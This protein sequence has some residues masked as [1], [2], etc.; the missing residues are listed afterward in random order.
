MLIEDAVRHIELLVDALLNMA[1]FRRRSSRISHTELNPSVAKVTSMLQ[2]DC[3]GRDVEW[4]IAKLPALD[5]DPIVMPRSFKSSRQCFEILPW[6]GP[7]R[8][9]GRQ[10]PTTG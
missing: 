3:N 1:V 6:P 8:N 5:C 7:R 2:P 4:R 10:H 9:R